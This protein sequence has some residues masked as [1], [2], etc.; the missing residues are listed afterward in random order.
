MRPSLSYHLARHPLLVS[1]LLCAMAAAPAI[2]PVASHATTVRGSGTAATETRTLPEF[3]AIAL[4]GGM[5]LVVRQGPV[6]SVQVLADDNLLPM[7]ETVVESGSKGATLQ[8]RWKRDSGGWFGG[9]N[10][11]QTRTKVLVTVVV[12]KLTA[13]S[14]AGAGD[15]R[16]ETFSTPVLQVSISGS[17]DTRLQGLSTDELGVRI[18]GSGN[19]SGQ[20]TA[21][22]TTVS[23]AGSGDVKLTEM[24]SDEVKVSI[25]G[26]GEAAVNAQKT[27]SVSIAGSGDVVYVGNAEVKSSV[28][29]SGSVKKK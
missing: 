4:N 11:V 12:P 27:L 6:Q 7:L 14:T 28:A 26:S 16:L 23:I 5:D 20:G 2:W 1:V 3:Q 18:S 8:V 15:I 25:A 9:S 29:G 21:A 17:G 10:S 22:R 19:V 24:R 13:L